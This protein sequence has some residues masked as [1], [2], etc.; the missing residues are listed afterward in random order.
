VRD[1][2]D[3]FTKL[4][5]SQ[6]GVIASSSPLLI[7]QQAYSESAGQAPQLQKE[8]HTSMRDTSRSQIK[9][10]AYRA[11]LERRGSHREDSIRLRAR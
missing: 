7:E 2:V 4:A 1:L 6:A 9:F 10:L 3:C 8:H 5:Q 11:R